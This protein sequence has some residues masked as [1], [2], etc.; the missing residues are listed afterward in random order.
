MDALKIAFVECLVKYWEVNHKW[1]QHIVVFRDGVGD[2]QLEVAEK[3]ES[4]QFIRAFRHVKGG[5]GGNGNGRRPAS[6]A[7]ASASNK[8]EEMLPKDYNP[9]FTFVV[10][11]KRIN[12]RIYEVAPRGPKVVLTI[13]Q[14]ADRTFRCSTVMIFQ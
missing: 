4:E 2:G 5:G 12:T 11:Q 13:P 8:L 6:A 7:G 3:H 1:P 14:L 9:G 10:V